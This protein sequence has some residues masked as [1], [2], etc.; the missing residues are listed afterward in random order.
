VLPQ[1]RA[2]DA[3]PASDF[4][5]A[6]IFGEFAPEVFRRHAMDLV[7][8]DGELSDMPV[9]VVVP[10][11]DF[12]EVIHQVE[13]DEANRKRL[14]SFV[15]QTRLRYLKTSSRSE[16]VYA[17]AGSTHNFPYEKPDFVLDV[18]ERAMASSR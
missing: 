8:Y 10:K 5:A 1:Y 17:P 6:S 9:L 4:A 15:A 2:N 7:V 11:G 12:D 18:V 13:L 16:L 3:G 14:L